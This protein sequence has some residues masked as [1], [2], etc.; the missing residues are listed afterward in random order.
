[1]VPLDILAVCNKSIEYS[2]HNEVNN[3]HH[4][5]STPTVQEPVDLGARRLGCLSP[6]FL[7]VFFVSSFVFHFLFN[8]YL[9]SMCLNIETVVCAVMMLV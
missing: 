9:F 7:F 5:A 1:M 2:P 4:V 3:Q 8:S 6:L